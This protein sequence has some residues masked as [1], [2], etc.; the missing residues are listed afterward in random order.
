MTPPDE[1]APRPGLLE[2]LLGETNPVRR[3]LY[4][5]VVAAVAL[6]VF[7]GRIDPGSVPLWLALAVAV[8]GIGGTEAA[9]A[10]A[11]APRSVYGT[12]HRY[13]DAW[14]EHAADEYARGVAAGAGRTPDQL[15]AETAELRMPGA[16]RPDR[17]REVE[18]GRR[19]RLAPHPDPTEGGIP[20]KFD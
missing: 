11:W 10:V 17:C 6:L 3:A 15:A 19:C 13:A 12:V 8:L 20:H 4:P 9:R 2:R 1:P 16:H 5:V 7:Y 18:D 14:Q